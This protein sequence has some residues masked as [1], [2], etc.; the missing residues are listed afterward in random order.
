MGLPTLCLSYSA[1]IGCILRNFPVPLLGFFLR[2]IVFPLGR[3]Y[4]LPDDNIGHKIARLLMSPTAS[5]DRLTKG[6][7]INSDPDDI[8]GRMEY[9]LHST[10]AAQ[11]IRRLLKDAKVRLPDGVLYAD[12]LKDLVKQKTITAKQAKVLSDAYQATRNAIMVD[13]FDPSEIGSKPPKTRK[14]KLST[15]GKKKVTRKSKTAKKTANRTGKKSAGSE[16]A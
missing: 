12:W 5:R 10:L 14:R 16:A 3:R 2:W 6:L 9:A 11:S 1:G 4:R 13:D 15:S 8:S 7:Y